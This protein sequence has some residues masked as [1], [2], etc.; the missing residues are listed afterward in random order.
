MT[1][2]AD[3]EAAFQ[4]I[5]ARAVSPRQTRQGWV[6]VR[7]ETGREIHTPEGPQADPV[8]ALLDAERRLVAAESE[9][10]RRRADR[11]L[12][13]VATTHIHPRPEEL[14][15]VDPATGEEVV[16]IV[17]RLHRLSGQATAVVDGSIESAIETGMGSLQPEQQTP[18]EGE[19][20]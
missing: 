9:V 11:L 4:V 17:W 7:T 2:D 15:E 14:R 5:A 6:A 18:P 1:T 3:R 8:T 16:R 10:E 12:R 13:W 20:R 19:P